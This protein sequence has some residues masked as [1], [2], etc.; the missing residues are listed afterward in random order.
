MRM[1]KKAEL[2]ARVAPVPTV[3]YMSGFCDELLERTCNLQSDCEKR[4]MGRLKKQ[5]RPAQCTTTAQ[6]ETACT[7]ARENGRV[8]AR[9]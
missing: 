3:I 8:N 2:R 5:K 4:A 7:G 6:G 1:R 9:Y